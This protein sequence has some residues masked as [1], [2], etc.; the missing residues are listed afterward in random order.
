LTAL[1]APVAIVTPYTMS[2]SEIDAVAGAFHQ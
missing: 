1:V 2:S